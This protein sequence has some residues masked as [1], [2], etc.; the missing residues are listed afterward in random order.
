MIRE[1]KAH[2]KVKLIKAGQFSYT[3]FYTLFVVVPKS[4]M[5][6]L[7]L[8]VVTKL[9]YNINLFSTSSKILLDIGSVLNGFN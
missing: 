3:H 9:F 4:N 7:F 1:N 2:R 8:A 6:S 5:S